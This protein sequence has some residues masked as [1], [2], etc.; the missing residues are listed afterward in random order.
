[1]GED[2]FAV[3]LT[4]EACPICAKTVDGPIV[5]NTRLTPGEARKVK[6]LQGQVLNWMKE[7]C[8]DCKEMMTKGFVL[9]GAV[10][11]KT[12]D[13]TNPYRSGNIW[14]VK[15]E[16]A[17]QLFGEKP[18]ASGVAFIDVNVAEQIKLPGVNINA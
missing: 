13:V 5:M 16:V 2:K 4:K 15:Q 8:D 3:A 7:P 9:I 17:I 12:T 18:P 11:K 1:M 10:E 14:V 6:E